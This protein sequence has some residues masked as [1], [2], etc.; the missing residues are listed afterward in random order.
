MFRDPGAI[1][2]PADSLEV[3]NAKQELV[4]MWLKMRRF[5]PI[6]MAI[7]FAGFVLC[8]ISA[9]LEY[10]IRDVLLK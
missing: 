1:F 5:V 9:I 3:R 4:E 8:I 6:V 7:A 2:D 10:W